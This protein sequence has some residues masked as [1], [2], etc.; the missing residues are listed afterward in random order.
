MSRLVIAPTTPI[1]AGW[2]S[3]PWIPRTT[4]SWMA[5][6]PSRSATTA[7][8]I[9]T[10][11]STSLR[12]GEGQGR[13]PLSPGSEA[14]AARDTPV[15]FVTRSAAP[16]IARPDVAYKVTKPARR[17]GHFRP[18]A[19]ASLARQTRADHHRSETTN[20]KS[21]L[22]RARARG[23]VRH[24]LRRAVARHQSCAGALARRGGARRP[25]PRGAA[26]RRPRPPRSA[27][28]WNRAHRRAAG[29]RRG[30]RRQAPPRARRRASGRRRPGRP[31][32]P[33]RADERGNGPP[34]H[35]GARA[36][37]AGAA[38]A[39][40]PQPRRDARPNARAR[41]GR[42]APARRAGGRGAAGRLTGV[43]GPGPIGR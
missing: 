20:A 14:R 29:A 17:S 30:D 27:P 22:S 8:A 15:P 38:G 32:G 35:R 5:G 40:R 34:R 21:Q 9:A 24:R 16:R 10:D 19:R 33:P 2:V 6:A 4:S 31:R 37:D 41:T 26:A 1:T 23:A 12:F 18:S 13:R 36:A 43:A 42:P 25:G 3:P 7:L 11:M 39:V 28:A